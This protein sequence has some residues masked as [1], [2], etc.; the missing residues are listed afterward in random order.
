MSFYAVHTVAFAMSC[1]F[2]VLWLR[3]RLLMKFSGFKQQLV[4]SR[5][6]GSHFPQ[7]PG[8]AVPPGPRIR[9]PGIS[10]GGEWPDPSDICA[11]LAREVVRV[12][13]QTGVSVELLLFQSCDILFEWRPGRAVI[14]RESRRLDPDDVCGNWISAVSP[15][16]R[17]LFSFLLPRP[18]NR[19]DAL[20]LADR[21]NHKSRT[22][23]FELELFGA[24]EGPDVNQVFP[25]WKTGFASQL[26]T[27]L[28]VCGAFL[29]AGWQCDESGCVSTSGYPLHRLWLALGAFLPFLSWLV[30]TPVSLSFGDDLYEEGLAFAGRRL[31]SMIPLALGAGAVL[32]WLVSSSVYRA[33]AFEGP[34]D[35]TVLAVLHLFLGLVL[36]Y[37]V[38]ARG[39]T[40]VLVAWI[41]YGMSLVVAPDIWFLPPLLAS[42][43]PSLILAGD[44]A[45]QHRPRAIRLPRCHE[46][47]PSPSQVVNAIVTGSL[48]WGDKVLIANLFPDLGP[49]GPGSSAGAMFVAAAI[50]AVVVSAWFF[51]RLGPSL[52]RLSNVTSEVMC[53]S[54]IPVF[55]SSRMLVAPMLDFVL[56]ESALALQ[57]GWLAALGFFHL[58]YP[59]DL[60]QYRSMI[61]SSGVLGML[62]ILANYFFAIKM[63]VYAILTLV[64]L[65]VAMGIGYKFHGLIQ[66]DMT[67]ESFNALL[68]VS[69]AIAASLLVPVARRLATLPE[70]TVFWRRVARW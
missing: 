53:R 43:I 41:V 25:G 65:A 24:P 3:P 44:L 22:A 14:R 5:R 63:G 67:F 12:L 47:V 36:V 33:Q 26:T 2:H 48:F 46:W 62:F 69:S 56:M 58:A 23:I 52:S 64:L 4:S 6:P 70:F 59:H 68:L 49:A 27:L 60:E 42:L 61:Y 21:L 15:A 8:R 57:V 10:R 32:S 13:D 30:V 29:V 55:K 28:V 35:F 18:L 66:V 37:S 54:S 40:G 17:R 7:D 20:E 38:A 11:F 31:F 50:P 34:R 45:M 51:S 39:N 1:L 19:D 9:V 16:G